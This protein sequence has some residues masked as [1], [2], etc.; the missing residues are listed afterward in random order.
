MDL[1]GV[2]WR[3]A[4]SV[5]GA[6]EAVARL[7][8]AGAPV[9]FVTNSALRTPAQVAEKLASHGIPDAEPLVITA[10]MAAASLVEPG[11]RVLAIGSEGLVDALRRRGVELVHDGEADAVVVG[12]SMS[13]DYD[14]M[15]RAMRAIHGGARFIATN[16]DSTYPDTTGLL[17]GN[18]A[19]VAAVAVAAGVEPEIAG[20]PHEPIAAFTRARLG[21]AGVMVGDRPDTDGLFAATLGYDFALVLTGVVGPADLPVEPA[22]QFVAAD[23]ATLV[24]QL[25]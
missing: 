8:A 10:A 11:S 20:K 25:I 5:P 12:I 2:V 24:D 22:P 15:T 18:G 4:A 9:A 19:L 3:G 17:P 16:T 1:D 14:D 13:F 6:P 23:L 7:R 21:D